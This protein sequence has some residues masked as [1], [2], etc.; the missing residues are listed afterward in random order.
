MEIIILLHS[1][2][3]NM[4]GALNLNFQC[5]SMGIATD[6]SLKLISFL[7]STRNFSVDWAMSHLQHK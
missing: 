6:V 3:Q 4:W 7:E 1:Y 2:S 5:D